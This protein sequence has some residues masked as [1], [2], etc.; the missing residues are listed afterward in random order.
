MATKEQTIDV[1]MSVGRSWKIHEPT[2]LTYENKLKCVINVT[3]N[4]PTYTYQ[5]YTEMVI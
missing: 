1:S 2:K 5:L 3:K 4:R